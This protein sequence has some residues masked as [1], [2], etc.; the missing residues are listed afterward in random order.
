MLPERLLQR[1]QVALGADALDRRD[2]GAVGL[3]GEHRA[4]LHRLAVEVDGAGAAV[5]R[6]A[7]DVRARQARACRAGSARAAAAARPRPS[8]ARRSR[9]SRRGQA[10]PCDG[11][12]PS[13]ER[14]WPEPIAALLAPPTRRLLTARTTRIGSPPRGPSVGVWRISSRWPGSRSSVKRSRIAR[15]DDADLELA[16]AHPEAD[17]RAAAER[18]VGAARDLLALAGHEALGAE[19]CGVLPHVRQPVRGPRAVV[20]GHARGDVVAV[21]LERRRARRGPIQAGGYSRSVSSSAESSRS[22]Q[23]GRCASS[24]NRNEIVAVVVSWPANS[25]VITWSRTCRSES[26]VSISSESTSSPRA[27]D[28]RR[29]RDLAV[30]KLVE[31]AARG[32]QRARTAC[33]GRAAPGASS[34]RRRRRAR[35]RSRAPGRVAPRPASGSKPNSARIATRSASARAQRVEVERLAVAPAARA[36]RSASSSITAR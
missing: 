18:H 31:P 25:S 36:P 10:L 2:L 16:E 34:P 30:D 4:A 28:A 29:R 35:A 3:D 14:L 13:R 9:S 12:P 21:Q 23:S 24:Q 33:A 27:P 11:S 22:S 5:G 15:R 17:P 8:A 7:A 1:V 26:S 32:H 19:A 20:H 6:V